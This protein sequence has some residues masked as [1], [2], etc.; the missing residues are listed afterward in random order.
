VPANLPL[1]LAYLGLDAEDA[2]RL[3]ALRPTLEKHADALVAAFYR[4]LL[5]FD[6]TRE[7]LR[8]PQVKERLLEKQREYL[9]SLADPTLDAR[10]VASRRRIGETHERIGL[11]PQWYLGAYALYLSLLTPVVCEAF[12]HD[13][14]RGMDTLISL[15]K[16]LT[17]DAQLAMETYIERH[18]RELEYLTRE[19][20]SE[21]RQLAR[22]FADRGQEL[23]RTEA[24]ARAA[25]Q[26]A[27][28][29]TLVA[30]LAHEIGTP[31]GVIQGHARLLEPA[32]KGED[33]R[34]RVRT[35]QEQVGR[36]SRI[37]QTLLNMA[38]PH[39]SRRVPVALA[40]LL[41]TTLSFLDEKLRRRHVRVE[42]NYSEAPSVLGDPE[43]LQQLLLNLVLN[44]ADA[45]EEGG[46]LRVS[47]AREGE[48]VV[49]RVRDSGPGIAAADL[50]RVFE[51]FYTTK[52]A[53]Q[54]SGLGL[55]VAKGI[56][57]DHGGDLEVASAAG[58]GAEFAV[59]L[60][61]GEPA[62]A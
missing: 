44:A 14:G 31:M 23:R 52:Q 28:I 16:L 11:E 12:G 42:R 57:S 4:H 15:Q 24:R 27:S 62:S 50:E 6:R 59:R 48:E 29:G 56:A 43:Q 30:G 5:S 13:V 19:L 21:G 34:W 22:D 51:P 41:D 25:E 37:L 17:L 3:R 33:A 40:P 18:D 60:P 53:G 61:V 7:L 46:E 36:I 49:V 32:V 1:R 38:R 26:L 45:M 20:A 8:D 55:M 58:E 10:Y 54:G 9:L 47:L 35:I 2:Q 39:R